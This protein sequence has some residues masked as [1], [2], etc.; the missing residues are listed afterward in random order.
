VY[1]LKDFEQAVHHATGLV[2]II[3]N[4]ILTN[5]GRQPQSSL[6][7]GHYSASLCESLRPLM[8]LQ[9]SW[10]AHVD[11][12]I[13]STIQVALDLATAQSC[14]EKLGFTASQRASTALAILCSDIFENSQLLLSDENTGQ[15]L[16]RVI[17]LSLIHLANE[18]ISY[19]PMSTLIR[20]RL[21]S[22]VAKLT[23][24]IPGAQ[25][26]LLV[27]CILPCRPPLFSNL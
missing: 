15:A 22:Q 16:R 3:K 17:C 4:A 5:A 13:A 7:F 18:A 2:A 21:V 12:G 25:S 26:D 27:G 10:P 23:P 19:R 8:S 20:Y 6:F 24:D 9:A 1:V 11:M 14:S